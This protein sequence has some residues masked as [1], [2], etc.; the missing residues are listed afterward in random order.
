ME[1]HVST[2]VRKRQRFEPDIH[3]FIPPTESFEKAVDKDNMHQLCIQIGVPVARGTT[4]DKLMESKD[5]LLLEFPLALRV[6]NKH[7]V[8]DGHRPPWKVAYA[9]NEQELQKLYKIHRRVAS[10]MLVQEFHPG[11]EYFSQILMHHGQA[12]MDGEYMGEHSVPLAG[13]ETVRRMT[14]HH[15]RMRCDTIRIL[16]AIGWDGIAGVQFH[17]D[18]RTDRYIFLEVNPR[19]LMSVATSIRAGFNSPYLLWQSH[20]EPEKMVA[21]HYKL[22]LRMRSLGGDAKWMFAMIRGDQLPPDQKRLSKISTILR[23]LWHFGPWTKDEIFLLSDLKPFWIRWKSRIRLLCKKLFARVSDK[24]DI[25]EFQ[26]SMEED[27][28]AVQ[29]S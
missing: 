6:R 17:Y 27:K 15:E 10:N 24:E 7:L 1:P 12:F 20:F 13:G 29:T 26:K 16:Q 19:F 14:C 8:N 25:G 9:K 21:Q 4:L 2:L 18:P 5:E 23:F 28:N 3:L 22:G 11:V